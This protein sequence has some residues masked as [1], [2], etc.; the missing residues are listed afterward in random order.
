MPRPYTPSPLEPTAEQLRAQLALTTDWLVD[1]LE[2][3]STRPAFDHT[4]PREL[5]ALVRQP[6]PEDAT[7][8]DALLPLVFERLVPSGVNPASPGSLSYVNGGGLWHAALAGLIASVTNRFT[9]FAAACPGLAEVESTVLRWFCDLVGLPP[10]AG[11]VLL[12]GGSMANFTAMVAARSERLCGGDLR[13]GTVYASDQVHH[14]VQK[15]AVLAGLPLDNVRLVASDDHMRVALEALEARVR[16]DRAEGLQ[17]FCVVGV[18]GSTNTGAVDDL[19]GLSAIARRHGLWFHVDA[20]YGGFFQL[21]ERG[22]RTLAGIELC[23]S[24]TLDP[25]KSLFFPFGSGCLLVRDQ[26]ALR[27]AHSLHS[28]CVASLAAEAESAGQVN[29]ADLSVEQTREARGLALWLP[30]K[31]LG[32]GAFRDALNEKLDLARMAAERIATMPGLKLLAT[33][34]LSAFAFRAVMPGLDGAAQ[35]ALNRRLIDAVNADGRV[36]LAPTEVHGRLAV[37]VCVLAFRTHRPVVE[38]F[39]QRLADVAR[40]ISNPSTGEM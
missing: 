22:R 28:A 39:L 19:P 37:R 35:D 29:F 33:P 8:L 34:E 13:A 10:S 14:S 2:S 1:Y 15:A 40:Q 36:H 7:P 11:G 5:A 27:R 30:L 16:R 25:H 12:T 21:T 3:L 31:M 6:M 9:G 17:P 18:A 23:D 32:A 26:D 24:V 38:A 4:D 20:A